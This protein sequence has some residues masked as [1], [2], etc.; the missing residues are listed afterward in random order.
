MILP[1][2]EPFFL[3]GDVLLTTFG[4]ENT[5][6]AKNP[7]GIAFHIVLGGGKVLTSALVLKEPVI[8]QKN[9]KIMM[10]A[11]NTRKR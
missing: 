2:A 1:G 7:D 6:E 9:G 8:I 3:P 5:L 4:E 10:M 11:P